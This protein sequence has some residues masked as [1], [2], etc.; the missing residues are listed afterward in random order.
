MK[1]SD[2]ATVCGY[3]DRTACTVIRVSPSGKTVWLQEDNANLKPEWKPE[4]I[5]GGFSGHCTNNT[6]QK[7]DYTP[8]PNG[9]VYRAFLNKK[10]KLRVGTSTVIE[11]RHK[12]Y[13]YNF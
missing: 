12:F 7:Y 6:T 10:G 11:G 13:D 2:G 1:I 9:C 3:S 5:P 4:I 8:N